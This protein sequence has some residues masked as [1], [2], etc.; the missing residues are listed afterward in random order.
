[1]RVESRQRTARRTRFEEKG[2]SAH[3]GSHAADDLK[4]LRNAGKTRPGRPVC[5]GAI[6]DGHFVLRLKT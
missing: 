4:A 3:D 5:V 6:N 1:M 2:S